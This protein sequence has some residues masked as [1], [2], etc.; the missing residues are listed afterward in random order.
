MINEKQDFHDGSQIVR[1]GFLI[2][3]VELSDV[4]VVEVVFLIICTCILFVSLCPSL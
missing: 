2:M 4:I 3:Y 1:H